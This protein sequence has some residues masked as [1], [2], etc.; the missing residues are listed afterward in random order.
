MQS[1]SFSGLAWTEEFKKK[2]KIRKF[3]TTSFLPFIHGIN[4]TSVVFSTLRPP[5]LA[6]PVSV[7]AQSGMPGKILSNA[8]WIPSN[9]M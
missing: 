1:Y 9:S 6:G 2:K 5:T 4:F 3:I 7:K 8:G